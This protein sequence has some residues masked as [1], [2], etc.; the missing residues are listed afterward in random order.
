MFET[1]NLDEKGVQ[2]CQVMESTMVDLEKMGTRPEP[3][4]GLRKH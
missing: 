4:P 1:D 3:Q 2:M